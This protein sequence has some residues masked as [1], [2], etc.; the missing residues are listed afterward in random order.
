MP[1]PEAAVDE[2]DRTPPRKNDVGFAW[3]ITAVDA[4]PES[5]LVQQAAD[6]LF[7]LRVAATDPGHHAA[8]CGAVY[9]IDH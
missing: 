1:V 8:A 4:K 7:G 3:Q 9:D 2:D 5:P 6:Q